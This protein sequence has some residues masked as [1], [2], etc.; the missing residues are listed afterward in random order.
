MQKDALTR[1]HLGLGTADRR[2]QIGEAD[3]GA[4][5]HRRQYR[6][7]RPWIGAQIVL[8]Q[9]LAQH[10][11]AQGVLGLRAAH[12]GRNIRPN[13]PL[14]EGPGSPRPEVGYSLPA[15][16]RCPLCQITQ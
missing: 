6:E 7:I 14:G 16:N 13:D 11:Q 3:I 1:R 8:D 15:K 9:R 12:R 5:E 2:L 4:R 10:G